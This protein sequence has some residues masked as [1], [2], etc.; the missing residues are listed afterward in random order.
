MKTIIVFSQN[1]IIKSIKPHMKQIR[2]EDGV[3][4]LTTHLLFENE[5]KYLVS[6]FNKCEFFSFSDFL[7]DEEME[8]CDITSFISEKMNYQDYLSSI[9]KKKNEI[10]AEKVLFSYQP[11]NKYIFSN[12]LGID[13][14]VWREK[15]FEYINAK[16]YYSERKKIKF[17][18][19]KIVFSSHIMESIY[20]SIKSNEVLHTPQEVN[21]GY[22]NGRK[23]IFLGKLNRIDY[24]MSIDFKPS[25]E[26]CDRLNNKKFYT[27]DICTYLTTWHER[28]KCDVPDD[29][30][31][32]VRWAQDGYLPPNYTHKDY[33]FK[34]KNVVYY[35]WDKL[36]TQLFKNQGLQYEIIPFRK[37]LYIPKP[38]FP[39]RVNKVLIVASGSGD[40]TALKNRSDDDL[41]VK[42]FVQVAKDFPDIT[43]TYRCHPTWVH[44]QNVGVNSIKRVYEYFKSTKLP[45][46]V[47]SSNI[48]IAKQKNDFL[49]TFSRNSLDEDLNNTDFVFGE[50]SI[51]MIDGAFK[52][53]PFASVNLTKRRNF[54][55]GVN[56]LGFPTCETINEIENT[57]RNITSK[58]FQNKYLC[59]VKR[60]NDMTNEN[61]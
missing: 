42:A 53:I 43:F 6:L 27:K 41:L 1:L 12:D 44:P 20:K 38:L 21:V 61:C 46:I 36:G 45:N 9:K 31:Y 7:L 55:I 37:K 23:F 19:K 10:V 22:Y 8:A 18:L 11:H 47:I 33:F 56:E 58:N 59:A 13:S 15:G 54:F 26:E 24:R 52:G 25:K 48:P 39:N 40:W 30:Q 57:I 29:K 14:E 28:F 34:P 50:H 5:Q 16:Y 3:I 17:Y 51:S 32:E 2:V 60:Y 35:C 4:F 49:L